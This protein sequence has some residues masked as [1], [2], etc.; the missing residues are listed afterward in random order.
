MF[1]SSFISCFKNKTKGHN[2]LGCFKNKTKRRN[3]LG[4]FKNKTKGRN[5]LGFFE[6]RCKGNTKKR[7]HQIMGLRP[8][9]K[10]NFRINLC[11]F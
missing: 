10:I 2:T 3:T 8:L 1:N 4:C 7:S 11:T 9:I 5:T 6:I